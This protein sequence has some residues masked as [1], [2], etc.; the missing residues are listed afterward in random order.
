[1]CYWAAVRCRAQY[2]TIVARRLTEMLGCVIY[3]PRAKIVLP[4]SRRPVTAP[5]YRTYLFADIDQG[6]PWQ[7][8]ARTP[9]VVKLVMTGDQPSRCPEHEI[10]KLRASEVDGLVQLAGPPPRSDQKFTEG[11]AVKIR[12][13]AF[14]NREARYAKPGKR[15]MSVVM[16][17]LLNRVVAVQVPTVA[18]AAIG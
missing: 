6:P 3:L 4:R 7:A 18:L 15:N 16:V 1:M 14:D 13:G 11:Q 12:Y 5:L 2:E 17:V 10:E 8:I 9:G